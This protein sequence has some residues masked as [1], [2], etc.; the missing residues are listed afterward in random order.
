MQNKRG[1]LSLDRDP[2]AAG[3]GPFGRVRLDIPAMVEFP[4][5]LI[6]PLVSDLR[7]LRI[8]RRLTIMA[9]LF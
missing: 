9:D 8:V 1:G 3:N 5:N 2:L 6:S 7:G 4:L